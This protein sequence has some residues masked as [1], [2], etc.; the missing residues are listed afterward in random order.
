LVFLLDL[1]TKQQRQKSGQGL[2]ISSSLS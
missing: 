2:N 1:V